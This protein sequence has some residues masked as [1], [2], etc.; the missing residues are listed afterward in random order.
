MSNSEAARLRRIQIRIRDHC[1][2]IRSAH[3]NRNVC[4][5]VLVEVFSLRCFD[6]LGLEA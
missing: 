2:L 6:L 3:P 1:R 5:I 4:A